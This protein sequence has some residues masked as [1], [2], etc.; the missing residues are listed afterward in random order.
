MANGLVYASPVKVHIRLFASLR[1]LAGQG[2][3]ALDL[4][5]GATAEDAWSV[6]AAAHPALAPRRAH[7][8]AAVNRRYAAFA[9]PLRD[10]DEVVFVPP[11]SGG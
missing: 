4:P 1:E 2:E 3:V 8:T 7:L 11:V 6:L 5:D 10:G 9:E